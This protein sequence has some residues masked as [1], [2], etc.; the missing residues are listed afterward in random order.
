MI[1][2][3]ALSTLDLDVAD[4][5]IAY[6][7]KPIPIQP[8]IKEN[9]V[10]A[11]CVPIVA[12]KVRSKVTAKEKAGTAASRYTLDMVMSKRSITYQ[13][14]WT[15][16]QDSFKEDC[17]VSV[18]SLTMPTLAATYT[19]PSGLY[20]PIMRS[21]DPDFF[22]DAKAGELIKKDARV[23][24]AAGVFFFITSSHRVKLESCCCYC[25]AIAPIA[26]KKSAIVKY[27]RITT[28]NNDKGASAE[29]GKTN[30][31]STAAPPLK[32]KGNTSDGLKHC[33]HLLE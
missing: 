31:G 13:F 5:H 9:F 28:N 30:P 33:Q 32:R 8:T 23:K 12:A 1:R 29:A 7:C 19:A 11:W 6:E 25:C 16:G 22:L 14:K 17:K 26:F 20:I 21:V 15:K 4:F 2:A 10:P 27:I 24:D 18:Y 3:R